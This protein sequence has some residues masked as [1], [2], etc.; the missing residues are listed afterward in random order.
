LANRCREEGL[1]L[2]HSSRGTS[3][4]RKTMISKIMRF[5]QYNGEPV[6]DVPVDYLAWAARKIKQTPGYVL[7]ELRRRAALQGTR[8][9]IE[10]ESALS[11]YEF[12]TRPKSKKRC[13]LKHNLL[14][15]SSCFS[16]KQRKKWR[17]RKR[18]GRAPKSNSD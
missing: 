1:S 17:G 2:S 13:R 18:R 15:S 10:A 8:D 5:G 7:A 3:I 16:H 4:G 6:S 11:D 12:R 9:S 14:S